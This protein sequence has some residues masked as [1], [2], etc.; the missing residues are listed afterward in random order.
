[1][2]MDIGLVEAPEICPEC[3][4]DKVSVPIWEEFVDGVKVEH[5]SLCPICDREVMP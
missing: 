2:I 1:M 5:L 3:G 4:G